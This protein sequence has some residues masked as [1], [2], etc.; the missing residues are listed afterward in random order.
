[1]SPP[2][3]RLRLVDVKSASEY[4]PNGEVRTADLL[5]SIAKELRRISL[6]ARGPRDQQRVTLTAYAN[7]IE[8]LALTL[9]ASHE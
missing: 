8:R 4:T 7:Q 9:E 2:R 1:M 6:G 3:A 5:H